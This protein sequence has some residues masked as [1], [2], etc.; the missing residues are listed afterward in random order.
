MAIFRIFG[1]AW[2]HCFREF[3]D[4]LEC[5]KNSDSANNPCVFEISVTVIVAIGTGFAVH[6]DPWLGVPVPGSGKCPG[7]Y[8]Y[9]YT[10]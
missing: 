10:C 7:I 8:S 6:V 4:D 2:S 3:A 5:L 1:Y 9:T